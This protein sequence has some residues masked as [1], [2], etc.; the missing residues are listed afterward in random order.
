ML[1]LVLG[2]AVVMVLSYGLYKQFFTHSGPTANEKRAAQEAQVEIPTAR[3][4]EAAKA[5][6]DQMHNIEAQNR[7]M[8]ER[9]V[10]GAQAP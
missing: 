5:I 3:P 4:G 2:L 10:R 9:T 8:M 6:T 7:A 1:R